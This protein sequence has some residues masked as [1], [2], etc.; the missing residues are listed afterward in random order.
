KKNRGQT[1][2]SPHSALFVSGLDRLFQATPFRRIF[3]RPGLRIKARSKHRAASHAA[4]F[5]FFFHCA[6]CSP[7]ERTY[8]LSPTGDA[9]ST[10]IYSLKGHSQVWHN[11]GAPKQATARQWVLRSRQRAQ[12]A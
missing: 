3:S 11:E 1:A 2:P 5:G 4:F 7:S 6:P 9:R 12:S 8:G 10:M